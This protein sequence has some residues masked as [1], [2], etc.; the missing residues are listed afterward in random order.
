MENNTQNN[1]EWEIIYRNKLDYSLVTHAFAIPLAFIGLFAYGL[2]LYFIRK[3]PL[4]H[5]AFGNLCSAYFLF[6]IQTIGALLIWTVVRIFI[7]MGLISLSW[8]IFSRI[9]FPLA[10]S[11]LYAAIWMQFILAINRLW[12]I[13]RPMTYDR[14]FSPKNARIIV[15]SFWLFSI[16]ITALYYN[17]ECESY[18][19]ADFYSWSTLFGP[20]KH[21]FLIYIAMSLSDGFFFAILIVDAVASYHV[22]AY[23]KVYFNFI[24]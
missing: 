20:C 10:N 8:H 19:E 24:S 1:T 12:A 6:Q 21:S 9:V 16:L 14:V 23:L 3:S 5:N 15:V 22:I 4:Y 18:V 17:V 13:S 2:S 7:N 11:T